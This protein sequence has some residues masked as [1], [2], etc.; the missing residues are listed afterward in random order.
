[1]SGFGR[2]PSDTLVALQQ[3]QFALE[4]RLKETAKS[5]ARRVV[6]AQ[7]EK[8]SWSEEDLEQVLGALNLNP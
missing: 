6:L 4:E 8:H 1:V 2:H 3:A 7:S 5:K